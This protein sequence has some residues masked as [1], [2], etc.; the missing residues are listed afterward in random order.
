[1]AED[2]TRALRERARREA[3]RQAVTAKHEL[4]DVVLEV[5]DQYFPEAV[6][7]RRRRD[8]ARGFAVGVGVGVLIQY[9][10]GQ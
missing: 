4:G 3:E 1:M 5:T 7:T 9:L 8:M 2:I 6:R 10:L